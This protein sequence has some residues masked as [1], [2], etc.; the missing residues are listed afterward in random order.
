M[1]GL[2]Q[3]LGRSWRWA[4]WG[5][6]VELLPNQLHHTQE[7][8]DRQGQGE[9]DRSPLKDCRTPS[10]R[11]RIFTAEANLSLT[12]VQRPTNFTGY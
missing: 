1:P 9:G 6:G 2:R 4:G 5:L 10:S 7:E 3:T 8:G 12:A 11:D